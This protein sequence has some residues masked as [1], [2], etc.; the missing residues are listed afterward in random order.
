MRLHVSAEKDMGRSLYVSSANL[1]RT[2]CTNKQ[3][4]IDKKRGKDKAL[5]TSFLR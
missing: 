3:L 5:C 2:L 1:T 4:L